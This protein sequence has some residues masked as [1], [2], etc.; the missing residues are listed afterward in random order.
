[1]SA[2]LI[3]DAV[4]FLQRKGH[5]AIPVGPDLWHVHITFPHYPSLTIDEDISDTLLVAVY[6]TLS[7]QTIP[8]IEIPFVQTY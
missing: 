3:D 4:T 7:G 2:Q 8:G 6:A 1:M 5:A